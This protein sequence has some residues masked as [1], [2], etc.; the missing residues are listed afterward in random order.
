[1]ASEVPRHLWAGGFP[2]VPFNP[3]VGPTALLTGFPPPWVVYGLN[4][5]LI[6]AL[7]G[8]TA[9]CL[10]RTSSLAAGLCWIGVNS[11]A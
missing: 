11:I 5:G 8:V 1:M 9:G 3:P 7:C 6:F 10:T 2:D 4:A